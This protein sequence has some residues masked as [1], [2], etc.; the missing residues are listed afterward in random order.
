LQHTV[1]IGK[2]DGAYAIFQNHVLFD[3]GF[4]MDYY[5]G[6][7]C[8]FWLHQR[9][10]T[11]EDAGRIM[12]LCAFLWIFYGYPPSIMKELMLMNAVQMWAA[13]AEE[14]LWK[15]ILFAEYPNR[16][17]ACHWERK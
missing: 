2:K 6:P 3:T 1:V 11:I 17:L 14:I 10:L 9:N 4:E 16:E 7:G 5:M 13:L 12:Q 8:L 15:Q